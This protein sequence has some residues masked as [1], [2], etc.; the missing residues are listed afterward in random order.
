MIMS[1]SYIT[2]ELYVGNLAQVKTHITI[3]ITCTSGGLLWITIII[4]IH[5]PDTIKTIPEVSK[6]KAKVKENFVYK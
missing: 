5:L 4:T 3:Y 2:S 1:R 6:F